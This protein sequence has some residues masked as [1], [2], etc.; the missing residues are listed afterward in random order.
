MNDPNGLIQWAGRYHLF[1]QHNP[2]AATWGNIHWGHAVSDDL[3]HWRDLPLALKPD[4]MGPDKDG[5]WSGVIVD[6]AGVPTMLYTGVFPETQCLA[7]G[8]ADL[9][10]WHKHPANPVLA[11]APAHLD[12][13]GFRDPCV[14]HNG[15]LWHMTLGTGVRDQGGAVLLYRSPDLRRW[16]F[17]SVLL[18]GTLETDGEMWECPAFF[19]LADKWVLLISVFHQAGTRYFVGS[20]DGQT[21]SPEQEGMLD[22]GRHFYAPQTLSD[23]AGRRVMIGWLL[24]GRS[25]TAQK[26]AGWSGAQ[27]IPRVLTLH[28]D[29]RLA[30]TPAP[31]LQKVRDHHSRRADLMLTGETYLELAELHGACLELRIEMEPGTLQEIGLKLLRAPDGK[32][33]TL[34]RVDLQQGQLTLD[35]SR[36]GGEQVSPLTIERAPIAVQPNETLV[37]HVFLDRSIIEVFINDQGCLSG[38]VYP[39]STHNRSVVFYSRGGS[40]ALKSLEGWELRSIWQ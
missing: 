25:E 40:G 6:N 29:Q 28:S 2:A 38:R 7:T 9:V 15:A 8:S 35:R 31:E 32:Q 5:C 23:R 26:A 21:F 1:Y 4:P 18:Q 27:S 17:V 24:E 22:Y 20:F 3:V 16:E 14:W 30:M 36:S 10:H 33:E 39:P 34:I 13:L 19:P 37:L 12:V 11:G